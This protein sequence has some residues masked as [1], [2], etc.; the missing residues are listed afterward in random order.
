[1]K[2]LYRGI[3]YEMNG[4]SYQSQVAIESTE[5]TTEPMPRPNVQLRYRGSTYDYQPQP[6]L[7]S[8]ADLANVSTVTLRYRGQTYQRQVSVP[9]ADPCPPVLHHSWQWGSSPW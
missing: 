3:P 4:Q 6:K 8:E 5:L 2:L 1:M 9:Q 7:L